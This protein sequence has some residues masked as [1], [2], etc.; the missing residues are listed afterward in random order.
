MMNKLEIK[1]PMTT[2]FLLAFVTQFIIT[3]FAGVPL[4]A[5]NDEFNY[6]FAA[7]TF[8][9]GQLTNPSHP[10]W[11][12]FER[13]FMISIPTFMPK[14]QPGQGFF[15]ALGQVLFGE[16]F[17]G[18]IF[19]ICLF[20]CSFYWLLRSITPQYIAFPGALFIIACF[21]PYYWGRTYWGGALTASG[22]CLVLGSYLYSR[23]EQKFSKALQ[24]SLGCALLFF[25]R[26]FEGGVFF[27]AVSL[28]FIL[29][30][31]KRNIRLNNSTRFFIIV[32][33]SA[34]LI[35]SFQAFYNYKVTG[36]AKTMPYAL[37]MKQ[38]QAA[39]IFWFQGQ[40]TPEMTPHSSAG[41]D[42]HDGWRELGYYKKIA[43]LSTGRKLSYFVLRALEPL[44][45]FSLFPILL[46]TAIPWCGIDNSS[47][48]LL[49]IILICSSA[50]AFVVWR[51]PHYSAATIATILALFF[52]T[53]F[54]AEKEIG[55]TYKTKIFFSSALLLLCGVSLFAGWPRGIPKTLH[56]DL[57]IF[58]KQRYEMTSRLNNLPT[59]NL[60][61]VQHATHLKSWV[62]NMGDI[63][64][65]KTIFANDFGRKENRKLI[66]YYQALGQHRKIWL[67][68]V[69]HG[70]KLSAY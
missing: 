37:Y 33:A 2:I 64:A 28:C 21:A 35:L 54:R 1:Y 9:R 5:I 61:F 52:Y 11:P 63:D 49:F 18:V 68:D 6:L 42:L 13:I 38:Y 69:D 31:Y 67:L 55:A 36:N 20:A 10:L 17:Y 14:F 58:S 51:Y 30:F 3:H 12:F 44:L 7:D 57:M 29:D 43:D 62:N 27:I 70:A 34:V 32:I 60:I 56:R 41:K 4:P 15:L 50:S 45:L 47:R 19:S 48:R 16:P 46:L 25:T 8:A 40:R 39:P 65:Q 66:D 26:P 24:F 23:N 59:D 22:A 53:V